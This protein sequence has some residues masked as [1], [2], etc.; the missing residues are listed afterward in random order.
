MP[1]F[2]VTIRRNGNFGQ[3][4][5][6]TDQS[7]LWLHN[8]SNWHEG[9][10]I[11][12]SESRAIPIWCDLYR[13]LLKIFSHLLSSISS[14]NTSFFSCC[15]SVALIVHHQLS[16]VFL[17]SLS[18]IH[19]TLNSPYGLGCMRDCMSANTDWNLLKTLQELFRGRSPS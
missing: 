4:P 17:V 9:R 16:N 13:S 5:T 3:N 7:L 2:Q 11:I 6:L 18:L 10:H 15:K 8:Y 19:C 14:K 1:N 12:Q